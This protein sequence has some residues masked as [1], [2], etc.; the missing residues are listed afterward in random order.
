M[1]QYIGA[2]YVPI[3]YQNSLD[4]TSSEWEANVTYEPMTWVSLSNG[5][6]Y[7][8]KKEVPANIGTPAQNGEYWLEAG[9]YNAYIQSLQDQ[10][11]DMKDGNISG[12]LQNQINSNDT[13]IS[14]INTEISN[15]KNGSVSGSLQNQIN[16]NSNDIASLNS[17]ITFLSNI[18]K[19]KNKK[20]IFVGDSYAASYDTL[21]CSW[22]NDFIT[23][24]GIQAGN[25]YDA[26]RSGTGFTTTNTFLDNVQSVASG[27][28]QTEKDD[29]TD[30]CV[31]GG[32]NDTIYGTIANLESDIGSFV[33]YCRSTFKNATIWIGYDGNIIDHDRDNIFLSINSFKDSASKYGINYLHNVEYVLRDQRNMNRTHL[34][35]GMAFHP[36]SYGTRRL[37]FALASCL[38]TGTYNVHRRGTN[39]LTTPYIAISDINN[40]NASFWYR[41]HLYTSLDF[42]LSRTVPYDIDSFISDP[43]IRGTGSGELAMAATQIMALISY[44]Q[45][46]SGTNVQA[47]V[48]IEIWIQEGK[49]K[50][51]EG[52]G[53]V[54]NYNH[55]KAIYIP[56]FTINVPTIYV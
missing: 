46:N 54:A 7:I 11:D 44:D 25:Y 21:G 33:S 34:V 8:S 53:M 22:L 36:N 39:Q 20:Y 12:S 37:S 42:T 14:T 5:Y 56:T 35:S 27:M 23:D 48:P 38:L 3:F 47:L 6:M 41:G 1:L 2:R 50:I 10:I 49:L 29:I 13:D 31:M 17:D 55:V 40:G 4:P 19:L 51:T 43:V 26:T 16:S 30:I 52:S 45:N 24:Y 15:M 9:Q 32:V 28:T 18:G